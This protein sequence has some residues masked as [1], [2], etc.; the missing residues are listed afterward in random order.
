MVAFAPTVA[1]AQEHGLAIGQA[2]HCDPSASRCDDVKAFRPWV[3][4]DGRL[5]RQCACGRARQLCQQLASA[6]HEAVPVQVC[7]SDRAVHLS[8]AVVGDDEALHFVA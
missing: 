3:G 2:R 1:S 6:T 4:T 8:S 5:D 7:P